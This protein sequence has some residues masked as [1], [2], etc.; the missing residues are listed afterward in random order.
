MEKR[1]TLS[2]AGAPESLP[3]VNPGLSPMVEALGLLPGSALPQHLLELCPALLDIS[4]LWD[5]SGCQAG[6]QAEELGHSHIQHLEERAAR[7]RWQGW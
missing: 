4:V 6:L 1:E 7:E 5:H 2:G 3:G